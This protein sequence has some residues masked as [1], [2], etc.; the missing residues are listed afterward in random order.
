MCHKQ[1]TSK[2]NIKNIKKKNIES[3][4]IGIPENVRNNQL[5]VGSYGEGLTPLTENLKSS[6]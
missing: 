1:Y 2:K 4:P 5:V 6:L 3:S